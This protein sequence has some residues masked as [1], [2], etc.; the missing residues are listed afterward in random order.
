MQH[1][2]T[3]LTLSLSTFFFIACATPTTKLHEE[4]IRSAITG[5]DSAPEWVAG[6]IDSSGGKI[7]FVGR[8]GAFNV[9]DERKAFDEALM[10]ARQ[11]LAEFVGTRVEAEL[12]D[13]DWAAGARYVGRATS[14]LAPNNP[15]MGERPA[16]SIASRTWQFTDAIIGQLLP[17]DQH[18]EQWIIRDNGRATMRRYKCW[19]LASISDADVDKFVTSTLKVLENEAKVAELEAANDEIARNNAAHADALVASEAARLAAAQELQMLRERVNYGRA[20]RLTATD[21]CP[22]ND[23][24][25]PLDRS[26]WRSPAQIEPIVIHPPAPAAAEA[27]KEACCELP[28]VGGQ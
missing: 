7:S 1:V 4:L 15:G 20:F 6:R 28:K 26:N 27:A 3:G 25:V 11:Q 9:L 13:K 22:V 14:S 10:H 24:C 2:R 17:V 12:C 16:Q 8:G 18:W 5:N 23:H 19:V 21:N